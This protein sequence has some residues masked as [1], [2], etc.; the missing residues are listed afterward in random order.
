MDSAFN[1]EQFLNAQT[2][3]AGSRRPPL[4]IENPASPDGL[5]I[6]LIGEPKM[7][8][9]QGKKDPTKS[10]M[11]C[12][13]PI[14]IDVPGQLQDQLKLPA[15]VRLTDGLMLDLT[16]DNKAIDW[17][18]GKNRRATVFREACNLNAAGTPF[19]FSMFNG[20]VIKVK[21]VQELYD[22]DLL[23]KVATVLKS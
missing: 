23:D 13:L 16:A 11:I 21:I 19:A 20:K 3:E 8:V 22:G 2:T 12:D 1:P 6:G 15:Q 14:T 10:Y 5:Y 7:R 18:P 17:S 9:V 4:P